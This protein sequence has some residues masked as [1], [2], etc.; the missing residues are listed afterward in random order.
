MEKKYSYVI[1][2]CQ[3]TTGYSMS[4]HAKYKLDKPKKNCKYSSNFASIRYRAANLQTQM[5]LG[6]TCCSTESMQVDIQ[7]IK[8]VVG[9]H[10]ENGRQEMILS[11]PN[12]VQMKATKRYL[13]SRECR[14]T[15]DEDEDTYLT[16]SSFKMYS[17]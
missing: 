10:E 13:S 3:K 8:K 6:R 2:N 1:K 14:Q 17:S 15:I 7:T 12:Q 9:R 5:Q 4:N 11:D 16:L